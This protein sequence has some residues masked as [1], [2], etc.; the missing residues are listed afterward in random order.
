[1]ETIWKHT[2]DKGIFVVGFDHTVA[3]QA[4]D[5]GRSLHGRVHGWNWM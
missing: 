5:A 2:V 3:K 1:M 4:I